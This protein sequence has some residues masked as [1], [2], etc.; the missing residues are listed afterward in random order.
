MSHTG[1]DAATVWIE[2]TDHD[3]IR[4]HQCGQHAHGRDQPERRISGNGERKPNHIGLAGAPVA[5][6]NRCRALPIDIARTFNVGWYQLI[7]LKRDRLARRGA[8]L[9]GVG[10]HHP[11][12]FNAADEVSCRAGA[13]KCSRCRASFAPIHSALADRIWFPRWNGHSP[14]IKRNK[15]LE[16][17]SDRVESQSSQSWP[18]N[19]LPVDKCAMDSHTR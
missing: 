14:S 10:F 18:R 15:E 1:I 16:E 9:S 4:T 17:P 6:K 13:I 3:I 5:V 7:R 19:N 11:L 2:P 12:Y 8:L